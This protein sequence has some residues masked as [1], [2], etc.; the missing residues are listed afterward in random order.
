MLV[1][2]ATLLMSFGL[3]NFKLDASADSLTLEYDEDL[4]Y[5]REVSKRYGSDNFLIITFSPKSGDLL[6]KENL[7]ILDS[8]S[9]QLQDISGIEATIS[10]LDVPLLYSPKISISDLDQPLNTVTSDG[11]DKQLAKQEFL[12]SPIYKDMLLS[13]DGKTTGIVATLS[14]DQQYLSLVT[15][16]DNLRLLR[17]TQGLSLQQNH[18]LETISAEF[19]DYRTAKTAE[20]HQRVAQVRKL[21]DQYRDRATIYLGGPDMITADMIDF[22]KSDLAIFG[23]GILL[24]MLA[25]LGFIFRALRWVI[26]PVVTCAICLTIVLGFLSWIDWRLTV[27]SSNFVSLLL[28]IT[29]ALT[30]HLIVRYRELHAAKTKQDQR[31]LVTETIESMAKPCLY[32]VL[33]TIVAFSSLVVSNIRPVIDFGWMMTIGIVVALVVSFIVMP[34]GM[35]IMG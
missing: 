7:D 29:L 2:A 30:I 3:P 4:N 24:F 17:D 28:I 19:L 11:V 32:T 13:A 18:E 14:L 1:L 23:I 26:L 22:I 21:M 31:Q 33:T 12:T 6:D 34:A 16:R 9:N 8:I 10:M 25:T 15:Q 27:I 5:F 35:M 20:D